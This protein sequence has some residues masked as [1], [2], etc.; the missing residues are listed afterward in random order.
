MHTNLSGSILLI[1]LEELAKNKN[2][3]CLR[4][5]HVK[6]KIKNITCLEEERGMSYCNKQRE[7]CVCNSLTTPEG[8]Y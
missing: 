5:L 7:L 6:I 8:K 2:I 3:T 4:I 1:P